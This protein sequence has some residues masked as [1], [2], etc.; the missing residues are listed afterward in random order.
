[1]WI[2]HLSSV[3]NSVDNFLFPL[4]LAAIMFFYFKLKNKNFLSTILFHNDHS[5]LPTQILMDTD[6]FFGEGFAE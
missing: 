3:H 2:T 4:I 6:C 5:V 1:M